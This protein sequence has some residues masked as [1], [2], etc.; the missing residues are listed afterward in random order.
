MVVLSQEFEQNIIKTIIG[1][2]LLIVGAD[3]VSSSW[4]ITVGNPYFIPVSI[5]LFVVGGVLIYIS[6]KIFVN[7]LRAMGV[8]IWNPR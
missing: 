1:L 4:F 5:A 2:A 6:V 3:L 8:T 7:I